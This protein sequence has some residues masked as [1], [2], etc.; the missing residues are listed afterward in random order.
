MN[1]VTFVEAAR[2]LAERMMREGGATPA[3]RIA[4]RVPPGDSRARPTPRG[5]ADAA[6]RACSS[7]CDDYRA[8]PEAAAQML[9]QPGESPRDATL[10]ARELAAYTAVA[11]LILNLDEAGDQGMT[12]MDPQLDDQ[13]RIDPPPF[14]RHGQRGHRHGGAGVAAER[15]SLRGRRYAPAACR[16]CRTSRPR[17]SASS[18][19]SSPARRRRWICS[20]TSRGSHDLRGTELPDSIRQGQRLTGMTSTQ[21]SFPGRAVDLQVRAARHS[22]APGSA[23]CCRTPRR[24]PTTSASSS[25]CTPRRS[26]TIRRVTF[27]Q[28]GAQ[29]AGR[30]SIGSWLSYGLGSENQRPA[31]VRRDDLAG[32]RQART[33]SRSTTA[34]GAAA[35]CRR[36]YQGVKFRSAGDPVLYL[37]NP[38][39]FEQRR[40]AG[41]ML[42]DLA[43]LNQLKLDEFGDPEIATR[44]AQ[45]EMAYRMQTSVPELTDLSNEPD[46]DL[47][48]V[49][50]RVAQARHLRRQLPAR[51][52]AGRARRALHP[53]LP[54]RLGPAQRLC[55]SRSPASASD[56]DQPARR[57]DPGPRS[58]AACS[59]TRS[60]SGAASSA[61]P[62][63]ARAR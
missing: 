8:D 10:D 48:A 37:S 4:L 14:L 13:L 38:A 1:D 5:A 9:W 49:R 15:G 55:R 26:T 53:A 45:Y 59:T 42:D 18:T 46:R 47:R 34:C 50:P 40:R 33:T 32:H 63:T 58:S 25:R 56:T 28:T 62:S 43:K 2:V 27:F 41:A 22:P 29:L 21:A 57:P 61:A 54:P 51:A 31:G 36:K 16:A 3:E 23:S 24:S 6:R 60:S 30:P 11:S 52:P 19:C 7:I 39:G 17:R 35:S 12:H 44:I 20:T